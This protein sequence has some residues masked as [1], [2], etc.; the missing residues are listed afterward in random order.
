[1]RSILTLTSALTF[2]ALPALVL[3]A[4]RPAVAQELK[5]TLSGVTFSDGATGS[6]YF[7]FNPTTDTFG[8]YDIVT[9]NG[10]FDKAVGATYTPGT[11]GTGY[12]ASAFFDQEFS[13]ESGPDGHSNL[14]LTT[15]NPAKS[16]GQYAL[17]TGSL[18]GGQSFSGSAEYTPTDIPPFYDTPRPISGGSLEVAPAAVP[19]ASTVLSFGLLLIAGSILACSA[20]RR[21]CRDLRA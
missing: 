12:A 2:L 18:L 8:N 21:P 1:M 15:N 6:G 16:P 4:V 9:T 5:Y 13:F 10:T 14:V 11:A 20:R 17:T 7:D 19:E 3:S